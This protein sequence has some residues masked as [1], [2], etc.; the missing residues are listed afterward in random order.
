[1]LIPILFIFLFL[2]VQTEYYF[3]ESAV[4]LRLMSKEE[5]IRPVQDFEDEPNKARSRF[6]FHFR[7]RRV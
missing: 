7:S 5:V 2:C 3:L 1:M 4:K 6:F